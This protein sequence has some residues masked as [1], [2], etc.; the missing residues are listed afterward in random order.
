MFCREVK[1]KR[2]VHCPD[3]SL[4]TQHTSVMYDLLSYRISTL[5]SN[6]VLTGKH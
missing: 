2:Y 6:G 1:R 3:N 4:L 5:M